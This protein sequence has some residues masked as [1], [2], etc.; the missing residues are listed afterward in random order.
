M[1]GWTKFGGKRNEKAKRS[2]HALH[3]ALLVACFL[4]SFVSSK[5]LRVRIRGS[6][7]F[8]GWVCFLGQG[9]ITIDGSRLRLGAKVATPSTADDMIAD[10]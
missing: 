4:L 6:F 3:V 7:L 8:H 9:E 5:G 1:M 2:L 10:A